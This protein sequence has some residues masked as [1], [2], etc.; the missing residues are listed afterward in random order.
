[1]F[2]SKNIFKGYYLLKNIRNGK[3][4]SILK[5]KRVKVKFYFN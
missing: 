2:K 1:M 4:L 3:N 5:L